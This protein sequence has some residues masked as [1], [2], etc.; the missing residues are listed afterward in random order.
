MEETDY[1]DLITKEDHA[2]AAWKATFEQLLQPDIPAWNEFDLCNIPSNSPTRL[3]VPQLTAQLGLSLN[4]TVSEVCPIIPLP[5]SFEA[6]L[7][8]IDSKQRREIKRKLRRATGA[9]ATLRVVG[10]EDDIEQAVE[11]FLD[12]L[13]R[14]TYEKRDWLNAGRTALFH[15]TAVSAQKAG[16]LQLMFMEVNGRYAATLFNFAYKNRIWVYNSGLD[17]SAFGNLSLG[18]VISAKAIEHAI[19]NGYT[20]FDFLRGDEQYKYRFGA[21]DTEIY[22]LH[23]TK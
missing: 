6:Y 23:I 7:L 11:D 14:S 15:E 5:E 1:L 2:E 13:Q 17:T 10:P 20:E 8:Q 9:E 16:T 3:I 21:K 12:L 22:R 4:E 19:Q 18:V